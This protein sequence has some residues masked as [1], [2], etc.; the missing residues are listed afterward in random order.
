M[1]Y[2]TIDKSSSFVNGVLYT[3]NA[4]T[5]SITG[6]G[7][8]PDLNWIKCRA[9]AEN[10][11]VSDSVRGDSGAASGYYTLHTN[12]NAAQF[13]GAGNEYVSGL[14]SDGFSVGN[15][16]QVNVA[17]TFVSWN[18]K[19]GTTS[20]LSGGTITPSAYS[21]NTTS[22]IGIYKYSGNSTSGATIAHGLGAA[23]KMLI[24]KKISA[25]G[26]W[27]VAHQKNSVY[28]WNSYL[29]LNTNNTIQEENSATWFL[30]DT[31][32]D[33]TNITLGN[34]TGI[35]ATGSDYIIYA[36]T[37]VN[38]YSR[39]GSYL[40]NASA[41]GPFV[42]TGFKPSI[43]MIKSFTVAE[44]W[45]IWDNKRDLYNLTSH[46]LLPDLNNTEYNYTATDQVNL[47]LVS[48]GFKMRATDGAANGN[49]ENY[50][51]MAFGQPIIS[52]SGICATAR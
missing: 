51:Y 50:I 21:I 15:N 4:S 26:D 2:S 28:P 38:G 22:G 18:W 37:E 39:F 31:A 13:G 49:G 16:D 9:A 10:H 20:G 48:N 40:G 35:N 47:D 1:A 3:G 44:S 5:Q 24:T 6:V 42:Y 41:D 8:Q 23:P 19:A 29:Y 14:D 52:N 27:H 33:A 7:F 34:G 45:W 11:V 25:T 17:Q 46:G 12:T 32:P 30:N 43:V 36:F